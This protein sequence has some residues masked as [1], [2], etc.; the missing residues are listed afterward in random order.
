METQNLIIVPG[1]AIYFGK[2]KNQCYLSEYWLGTYSGYLYEDEVNMYID[3]IRQ[4]LIHL[5]ND[6]LSFLVFSGGLTRRKK[7]F[8]EKNIS[9]ITE[10]KSYY[11]IAEQFNWFNCAIDKS[12][13]GIEEYALDSY[14]NLMYSL[15]LFRNNFNVFPKNVCI[16]GLKFKEKRYTF[17][18]D[19]IRKD[20][21]IEPNFRFY[22]YGINNP[23][24]YILDSGSRLGEM[25]TFDLFR[26]D[27][28]GGNPPLKTKKEER[29]QDFPNH[30]SSY[31]Y[32]E[33]RRTAKTIS[34]KK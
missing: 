3:H 19:S 30:K 34:E 25:D 9:P 20:Y 14:E 33:K 8:D 28:H 4:G 16:Y 15:I 6:P 32:P 5:S 22:Y 29:A 21:L 24:D 11:N 27:P 26:K 13:V 10:A 17:H 18:A 23:P 12:K 31:I 1:H 7:L 2:E